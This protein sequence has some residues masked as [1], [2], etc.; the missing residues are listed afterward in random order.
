MAARRITT[1]DNRVGSDEAVL[2]APA[3]GGD[4]TPE[5]LLLANRGSCLGT[6]VS[7]ECPSSPTAG[8]CKGTL[9]AEACAAQETLVRCGRIASRAPL[10]ATECRSWAATRFCGTSGRLIGPRISPTSMPSNRVATSEVSRRCTQGQRAHAA[11]AA[12]AGAI[13]R[14]RKKMRTTD[15]EFSLPVTCRGRALVRL[16]GRRPASR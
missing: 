8:C 10:A 3:G 5:R 9:R 7:N 11:Q 1:W 12:A 13:A 4:L 16:T 6:R 2:R 14:E 15:D